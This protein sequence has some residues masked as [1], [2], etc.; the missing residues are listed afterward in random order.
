MLHSQQF[1]FLLCRFILPIHPLIMMFAGYGL[2]VLEQKLISSS[3]SMAVNDAQ[4]P[5]SSS[6]G[7]SKGKVL[8]YK[9]KYLFSAS[10]AL[11]GFSWTSPL[12]FE[13]CKIRE[14]LLLVHLL[15]CKSYL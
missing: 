7:D 2:A 3:Q 14:R 8:T 12:F 6:H 9:M 4:S 11:I 15:P 5:S 10:G 1:E 13:C